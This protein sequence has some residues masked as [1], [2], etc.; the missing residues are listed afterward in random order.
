MTVAIAKIAMPVKAITFDLDDTLWP[1]KP[2]LKHAEIETY[3]WL[4]AN[5]KPLTNKFSLNEIAEFRFKL[6]NDNDRFKNQISQLRIATIEALALRSDYSAPAA[7]ELAEQAF[8]V[9]Y[10]LRQKVNCYEGVEELLSELSQ[11]YLLGTISNGNADVTKT[12]IGRHFSFALS[13]EHINSSKPDGLIFDTALKR[14]E[15][16]LDQRLQPSDIAHVGDDFLCDIVGAKRAQ[17][18]AIWLDGH[19]H[20]HDCIKKNNHQLKRA[21]ETTEEKNEANEGI[22]A[23]AIISHIKHLPT[24]LAE[25]KTK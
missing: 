9:H 24:A 20:K 25:L 13:A 14:T 6:F 10:Q 15:Q 11:N 2:T 5:A 23:D 19:E 3:E 16:L 21:E 8:Q 22:V 7:S 17:F 1:L 12:S 4:C 18:K